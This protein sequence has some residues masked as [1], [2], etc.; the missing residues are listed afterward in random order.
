MFHDVYVS[1][2]HTY[3]KVSR[4]LYDQIINTPEVIAL[5]REATDK[6][7]SVQQKIRQKLYHKLLPTYE[8][9]QSINLKQLHFHLPDQRSFLRFHEVGKYG[10]SLV[11]VRHSLML[12][13]RDKA[14]VEGFEEGRIY[15][16][17]RYVYPLFDEDHTYLGTVET[18]LSF[19]A[20]KEDIEETLKSKIDFVVKRSIV[21]RKVWKSEQK[22]YKASVIN[23]AYLHEKDKHVNNQRSKIYK[24]NLEISE[25]V[26]KRMMRN[27]S[28]AVYKSG[29]IVVFLPIT[30]IAGEEGAAYLINYEESNII[31]KMQDEALL[32]WLISTL[33]VLSI[34]TLLYL[35]LDK[36]KRINEMASYDTL[37]GLYNRS[38]FTAAVEYETDRIQRTGS[39]LSLIYLDIDNF[40]KINDNYGHETGDKVLHKLAAILENSTRKT[41]IVGRWGGE[42]FLILLPDT[43]LESAELL[44]E[45]LRRKIESTDFD[46]SQP[47]TCSFGVTHYLVPEMVDVMIARADKNLYQAKEEGK[48]RVISN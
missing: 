9:L 8:S 14:Y 2:R 46:I 3:A 44:A 37:T 41:D 4:L 10:D 12:A 43:H 42:E 5:F 34:V 15:N 36:M 38:A 21:E 26:S 39:V 30:N 27:E 1:T 28:F 32:M 22:N 29:Y 35:L 45:K 24:I 40:K 48:N 11:G 20:L 47:V 13:N 23:D 6:D 25:E 31:F 33:G 19:K 7:V 17:F 18:S 16:G